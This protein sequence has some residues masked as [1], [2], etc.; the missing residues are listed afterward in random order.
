MAD[1]PVTIK[2]ADPSAAY[3]ARKGPI[4]AAIHGVLDSGSYILGSEVAYFEREFAKYVGVASVVGVASGTDAIVLALRACGVG[5]GHV[6][7]TVSLTAVATVAAVELTGASVVLVE[8][9]PVTR[10]MD[11]SS[12]ENAIKFV[13]DQN[14]AAG[15]PKAIVPV[16]LYGHP[17][18]MVSITEIAR[19]HGLYVIEDC[20]QAH[21]AALHERK[22]GTWGTA[23]A[24]SFYPT[25]N[26]GA[27]GDAGAVAT[28][29]PKILENV[30]MLR[31]YGW[32]ESP[33]SHICGLNSRL[34][35]LQASILRVQLEYLDTDTARRR[36]IAAQYDNVLAKTTITSPK[37]ARSARH[38]YHQYVVTTADRDRL[39]SF[40]VDHGIGTGIHYQVPVH[41]QPAYRNRLTS[42]VAGLPITEKLTSQVLSLPVYPYLSD[43]QVDRVCECL[44]NWK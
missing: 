5:P 32:K 6:V 3:R 16:H 15:T 40:L 9:D 39:R 43:G 10:T 31:Q 35:E 22:M 42:P 38:V 17:A 25:K 44:S 23:A 24:F 26:L 27:L 30:R 12:L 19:K 20:A 8:V 14:C 13:R 2:A 11:P 33:V 37:V 36:H 18:D 1:P 29:D 41:L 7:F 4:D 34:D 21:G 28:D